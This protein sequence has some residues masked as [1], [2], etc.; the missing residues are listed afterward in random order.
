M[1]KP[2]LAKKATI[3]GTF[4]EDLFQELVHILLKCIEKIEI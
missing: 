3:K 1:Y 2:L 4:D